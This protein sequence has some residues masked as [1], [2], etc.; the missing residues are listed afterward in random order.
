MLLSPSENRRCNKFRA[1]LRKS[2]GDR[3]EVVSTSQS[4]GQKEVRIG[5]RG[6][7]SV[8][9]SWPSRMV[10]R[11]SVGAGS[12]TQVEIRFRIPGRLLGLRRTE[13]DCSRVGAAIWLANSCSS[14]AETR[15]NL[16][17]RVKV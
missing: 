2:V 1:S 8:K 6:E 7:K 15:L 5:A 16:H 13:S 9:C 4:A 17:N 11:L 3:H 10:K 14:A 12:E